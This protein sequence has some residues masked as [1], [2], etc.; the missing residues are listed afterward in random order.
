LHASISPGSYN[1]VGTSSGLPTGLNL[2][3]AIRKHDGQVELY[4]D[5]D[6]DTGEGNTEIIQRLQQ[7]KDRIEAEFGEPLDW[8]LLQGKRACRITKRID[9]GGWQ[10]RDIW[11]KVH[12][13]M[14]DAMIRL[15]HALRPY[16][17]K[18]P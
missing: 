13:E 4:I 8:E 1:W 12:E 5:A 17:D 7:Y 10:D 3:Y 15:D 16:L 9:S 11:P 6:K 2:N 14:I 18:L